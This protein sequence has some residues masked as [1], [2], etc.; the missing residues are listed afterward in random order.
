MKR[1]ILAILPESIGGRLTTTS[2]IK[3]FE[4]CGFE[5]FIVD[6][7]D[8]KA[9]EIV[10]SLKME[11]FDFALSYDF[12]AIEFKTD[13]KLKIKTVN[14]FSDVIESDCSG[15]YWK[16][17]YEKLKDK[18]NYVFYWD[19]ELTQ[20]A[21]QEIANIFYLPHAVDTDTYKNQHLDS[22]YDVM[23]AGR[24]TYGVRVQKFLELM[25]ALPNIKF[26]LYC[27]PKHLDMALENLSDEDAQ[28]LK[29]IYKGFINTEEKMCEAINK[30]KIVINYTSQ[31]KSCLNYRTFQVLACEK[32]LLT[33]YRKEIEEL[34]VPNEDII[35][36]KNDNEL[37]EKIND[38]LKNPQKYTK[39]IKNGYKKILE[40]HS[41]QKAASF[42]LDKIHIA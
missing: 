41:S 23:F 22:E 19:K 5:V 16:K 12:V 24:L 7:L 13:L 17:Y 40:N 31:G 2:L 8:K 29:K 34:F 35:Y 30:S 14:Y 25:N 10:V 32:L 37:A 4:K 6:K 1:K 33:D 27:I 39:I 42:I 36:Y 21:N 9:K 3:G 26:A 38:Y 15:I 11:E 18:D 20:D 28:K